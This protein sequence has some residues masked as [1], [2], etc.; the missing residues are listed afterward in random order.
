MTISGTVR[1]ITSAPRAGPSLVAT[2]PL[3][4][5]TRE[6]PEAADPKDFADAEEEADAEAPLLAAALAEAPLL[7]PAT[8]LPAPKLAIF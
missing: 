6:G 7:L 1:T 5:S 3:R 2:G 4:T 8:L